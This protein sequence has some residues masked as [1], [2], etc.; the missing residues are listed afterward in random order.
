MRTTLVLLRGNVN[1]KALV[2]THI[3]HNWPLKS[4]SQYYGQASDTTY[5]GVGPT[6][7][8]T[9]T[10]ISRKSHT[11]SVNGMTIFRPS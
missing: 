4:F 9:T 6:Y 11:F 2:K 1:I 10:V 5:V 3:Q 8:I 7:Y